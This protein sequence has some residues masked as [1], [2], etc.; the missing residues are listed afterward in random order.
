MDNAAEPVRGWV[1]AHNSFG[2]RVAGRW[3]GW[4]I[5]GVPRPWLGE[6]AEVSVDGEGYAREVQ[7]VGWRPIPPALN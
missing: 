2:M 7:V 5:G 6:Y 3:V 4:A 1:T